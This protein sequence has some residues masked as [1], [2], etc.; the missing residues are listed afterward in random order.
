MSSSSFKNVIYKMCLEV[1]YLIY[2][3]EKD[4]P[5]NYLQW[6]ICYKTNPNQTRGSMMVA[7]YHISVTLNNYL[8][9]LSKLILKA[10]PEP[11]YFIPDSV[12]GFVEYIESVSLVQIVGKTIFYFV[13]MT[14]EKAWIDFLL[15]LLWIHYKS[16]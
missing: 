13:Q 9:V 10:W 11:V 2:M 14:F 1:I 8:E 12:Y 6:F 7:L 4:L 3:Y 15:S 16:D 5:L